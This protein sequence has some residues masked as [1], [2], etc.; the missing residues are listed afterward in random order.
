MAIPPEVRSGDVITADFMNALLAELTALKDQVA[1]LQ[2][3]DGTGLAILSLVP[4]GASTDPIRIGT[5]LQIVGQQFR[6]SAGG[7]RVSFD[8]V[9]VNAFKPGSN[10][11]LLIVTVPVLPSVPVSG[12]DVVLRVE[13]GLEGVNR[14]IKVRPFSGVQGSVNVVFRD[15]VPNPVPDP[16]VAGGTASFAYRIQALTNLA[17]EFTLN[18]ATT[19]S[20][21]Q[22]SA[23][24]TDTAGTPFANNRVALEPGATRDI[25]VTI[26]MPAG[27]NGQT[28]SLNV[29]A[30]AGTVVGGDS[31]GFTV[32]Q[33]AEDLD[34]TI[35]LGS[36]VFSAVD[37]DGN[38]V[39]GASFNTGTN[40]IRL[41]AGV[42]G[43]MEFT[44]RFSVPGMYA[45]TVEKASGATGWTVTRT[46]QTHEEG[47]TH[48]DEVIR[49]T[50]K[51]TASATTP[52]EITYRVKREGETLS[53]PR[54]YTVERV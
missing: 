10:D 51:P 2:S 28:F 47:D 45:M 5:D 36:P 3:G 20:A 52:T 24:V 30:S 35:D 32:G 42:Q 13:N 53:Q 54:R 12:R 6:F 34:D 39:P 21:F 17:A 44:A 14:T 26:P 15:D 29:S 11:S 48:E 27:S 4:S 41:P 23:Q 22:E 16:F 37:A 25:V 38:P 50:L 43:S 1:D 33:A 49:F 46:P 18:V 19:P 7:H 40:T 31:R 8:G 9:A